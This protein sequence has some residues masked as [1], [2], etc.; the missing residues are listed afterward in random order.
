MIIR[1]WVVLLGF[2]AALLGL[3]VGIAYA[4]G[5]YTLAWWTVD[6]GG[7]TL[8]ADSYALSGTVGQPDASPA[9]SN[10]GYT[11]VAGFWGG[12]APGGGGGGG[13]GGGTPPPSGKIYLPIVT[14]N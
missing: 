2:V 10:G 9:L 8:A 11:L 3:V 1:R 7:G 13:G 12:I 5:G 14:N 6:G 4:Q